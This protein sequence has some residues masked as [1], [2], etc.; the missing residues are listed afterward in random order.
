[1]A[2]CLLGGVGREYMRF[3]GVEAQ[4]NTTADS[5]P[6]PLY[7]EPPPIAA[8]PR[9]TLAPVVWTYSPSAGNTST[10]ESATCPPTTACPPVATHC[11][12]VTEPALNITVDPSILSSYGYPTSSCT[13]SNEQL[14]TILNPYLNLGQAFQQC[15]DPAQYRCTPNGQLCPVANPYACG[16]NNCFKPEHRYVSYHIICS[17]FSPLLCSACYLIVSQPLSL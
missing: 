3:T 9:V 2:M 16:L 8:Y 17:R 14:C 5:T 10:A 15:Y 7:Y 12:G 13:K 4:T 1:M 11:Y 6:A